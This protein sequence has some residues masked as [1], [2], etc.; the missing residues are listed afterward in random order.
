MPQGQFYWSIV[1]LCSGRR[2]LSSTAITL[3]TL[4]DRGGLQ[5]ATFH[6]LRTYLTPLHK[7]LQAWL[8][9]FP[10]LRPPPAILKEAKN[11]RKMQKKADS[12]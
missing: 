9:P 3:L 2:C 1:S 8:K 5:S 12:N 11:W 4:P 10:D 6:I 7:L